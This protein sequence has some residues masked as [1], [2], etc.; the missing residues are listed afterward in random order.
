MHNM[1]IYPPEP[2]IVER[3]NRI[4]RV[5]RRR[6]PLFP[7]LSPLA[8]FT[9]A[10]FFSGCCGCQEDEGP[11]EGQTDD[12]TQCPVAPLQWL[13]TVTGT[14]NGFCTTCSGYDGS[15]VLTWQEVC[16]W[17]S[18]IITPACPA[19]ERSF[20]WQLNVSPTLAT[21]VSSGMFFPASFQLARASFNCTGSNT[22]PGVASF[23]THCIFPATVTVTPI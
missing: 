5:E 6:K 14:T 9:P 15:F 11:G 12:C 20:R 22:L 17:N 10:F 23:P 19:D 3:V 1:I 18:E 16:T 4:E 7:P 8:P 13:L 2:A 21:V